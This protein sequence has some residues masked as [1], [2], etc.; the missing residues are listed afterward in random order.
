M[1]SPWALHPIAGIGPPHPVCVPASPRSPPTPTPLL[2]GSRP[3]A[4]SPQRSRAQQASPGPL[5]L[6]QVIIHR[7]LSM[8]HPRPFVKTRFAP[9]GAVACLTAISD[10][11][12]TVMFR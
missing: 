5:A 4:D 6:P 8:F 10:F 7:L 3:R 9:Q 11:Y 2:P 12:Y 1:A